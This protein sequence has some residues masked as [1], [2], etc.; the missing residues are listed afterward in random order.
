MQDRRTVSVGA[1]AGSFSPAVVAGGLVFVSGLTGTDDTGQL[2]STEVDGQTRRALARLQQM[3]GAAGS[4]L[5]QAMSVTVYLARAADFD[6]M[7]AVYRGVFDVD[8]PTRTTVVADLADGALVQI[9]AIA[10]P[11]G[12]PRQVFLPKGWIKSPRPYS[13]VVKSGDLVFLSGLL[14]RKGT[15]DSAVPGTTDV[16]VKT[17]LD[18]AGTLLKTVGLS[19]EDVVAA[20][21]FLTDDGFF[22]DMNGRYRRYFPVEP[23]ARATA[24]TR[25]TTPGMV[26][27]MT[28]VAWAGEKQVLGPRVSPSLPISAAVRAGNLVF[29]SGA[30]DDTGENAGDIVKQTHE[31]FTRIGRT[32]TASGLAWRD[33]VDTTAY[34]PDLRHLPALDEVFREFFPSAPPARTAAGANLVQRTGMVE[35]MLTAVK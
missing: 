15:D 8:P 26:V 31:T 23:P 29:L 30:L 22:D 25:L 16:Q 12:A 5:G 9:S 6:A 35:V 2:V 1:S 7:N 18:N 32:L 3:L 34:L 20:R 19:Y 13:Y 24:I 14:S 11:N 27:E 33:V 17:I 4:S 10:V 21:V 28:L